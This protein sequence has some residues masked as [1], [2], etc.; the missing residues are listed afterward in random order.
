MLSTI[1]NEILRFNSSHKKKRKNIL[2]TDDIIMAAAP[3]PARQCRL[4]SQELCMSPLASRPML[5]LLLPAAWKGRGR[6][7]RAHA[8][9]AMRSLQKSLR[10][11]AIWLVGAYVSA[12]W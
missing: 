12:S 4:G 9:R 11:R 7:A 8:R 2:G 3:G 6:Q 1:S 10:C 5:L